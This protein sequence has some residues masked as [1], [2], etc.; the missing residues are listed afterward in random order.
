MRPDIAVEEYRDFG[1]NL[2]RYLPGA[3]AIPVYKKDGS[4]S[5]YL[6]FT[7]PDFGGV[8]TLGYA[9]LISPSYIVSVKHNGGY[10]N[11]TFGNGAQYAA[12]YNLINRNELSTEDF[13]APRLNKVVTDAAPY[14]T[15]TKSDFLANYQSRYAWYT[16][17]GTGTQAQVNEDETE[18]VT[19]SGAY[20]WKTGG[21]ISTTNVRDISYKNYL[22]YYNLGPDDADTTPL[23]IGANGGDSGSPVFAWDDVDQQWKLVAVH[24]GY[25]YDGGLYLKR[26]VAG[27]IPGDFIASVQETNTSPDITDSDA[28]GTIFWGSSA[29]TQGGNSWSWQGLADNYKNLAPSQATNEELDATKD[30]RFSGDGGVIELADAVNMGAGKLQFSADYSLISA[31]GADATW[32]GGGVEVDAGKEVLWQVNGV[33]ADALHKIGEGTLHIHAT[34]I[35]EGSLNT[36]AGT[37]ILDQQADSDGQKQAFSSVTLV[38]GRPTVVLTDAGQVSTS[39][40]FFGYRGGTLDLNGNALSFKKINHTDSGATLVNHNSETAANLTITGYGDED[41]TFKTWSS[42]GKGTVGD[43]YKYGN[44]YSKQAEYF[45][46]LTSKYGGYPTNQ[47]STSTWLYLGTDRAVAADKVLSQLNQQVFRG[48]IGE[49]DSNKTNG[50]LNIDVDIAGNKAKLALTGGMNLKGNLNVDRGTVLLSGQ[51]VAHA[52]GVVTDDDWLTSYFKASQIRVNNGSTFQVGEYA[53]VTADIV[54]SDAS[55]VM[56]GYNNSA[57]EQDKIWRCYSV[58]YSDTVSC[59]QP[60]RSAEE[61]SALPYS[62]VTGNVSLA[63]NASLYLGQVD[64]QGN[65]TSAGSTLVALDSSARWTMTGNSNITTLRAVS[66]AHLSMLPAGNWSAKQLE[67]DSLNATGMTLSLGVKPATAESDKL[68]IRHSAAGDS[69]ILD[70][71]LLLDTSQPVSLYED[72]VMVDAPAGTTHDYFTL[73]D[74]AR[75]FSLYTPDYL[76]KE[77]DNRV[78]WLLQHNA[79]PEPEPTP[80]VPDTTPQDP[81]PTPDAPDVT[82][83]QPDAAPEPDSPSGDT[84][85]PDASA[86]QDSAPAEEQTSETEQPPAFNPDDWFTI[87]DNKTLI[88]DTRALM[89]SRQYIFSEA[90][91]GMN[92]RASMLRSQPEKSGQW[93]TLEQ[94]K[95]G[96]EGFT[97]NQQTLNVGVDTVRDQQMFGFNASYTQGKTR[98]NGQ[99]THRLATVGVDYSWSSPAGWFVDAASRYMHLSQEFSFDPILGIKGAQRDSH[100]LAG[101]VKTGYQ[102]TLAEGAFSVSPYIGLRGG[103]MSG[104]E[105]KG[106]DAQIALS[107]G[108][109]YFVTSGVELKKRGIWASNPDVMLTAGLEYQYS[110]GQSGSRLTL[111]DS[112]AQREFSAYSDNRYRAHVGIE[113]KLSKNL[114]LSAKVKT[115]FGGTFRT[116]YSGIAGINYHF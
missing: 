17:V 92:S 104:Y 54:A 90:L 74:I 45:Q 83:Q 35:N 33:A 84:T 86:E 71:S 109:P 58:I 72:V 113:G 110:P 19:L 68:T 44:P 106:E 56:F 21:T 4:I 34:G 27:Y 31:T 24:V 66:G 70:V 61:Q 38:S 82:P 60:V 1:E 22:R 64:Y 116:D 39:N 97:I 75:G 94:S 78:Q 10:K 13:H 36:G 98:G 11:V 53:D 80:D 103:S 65:V 73:P 93:V 87:Q 8:S 88:R 91:S 59:S 102:F 101:S 12:T 20:N 57:D 52:G 85:A 112:R 51:P 62:V 43:I 23:S 26:A 114:S 18:R 89:A 15:V 37:V 95:G 76:V 30:L 81:E 9:T 67:V 50:E 105:V 49:T 115:S 77:T 2:G 3:T 41:V 69:N 5:G 108:S 46:L 29:I 63:D 32:T 111:G 6:E 107:S 99:E 47:T 28:E 16:R 96:F 14:D 25:D 7:M 48:F 40:I 55:R 100:I 42:S 79:V